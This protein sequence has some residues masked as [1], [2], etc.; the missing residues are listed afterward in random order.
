[1]AKAPGLRLAKEKA[2]QGANAGV[3]RSFLAGEIQARCDLDAP[4]T[5][6]VQVLSRP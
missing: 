4:L 5:P 3:S 2:R 1:V 6:V